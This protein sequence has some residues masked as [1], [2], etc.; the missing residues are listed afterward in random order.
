LSQTNWIGVFISCATPA[1]STPMDSSFW[2]CASCT[3]STRCCVTSA[4]SSSTPPGAAPSAGAMGS[5]VTLR[6]PSPPS[7]RR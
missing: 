3:W 5:N 6:M 2:A 1:A 7:A 4:P